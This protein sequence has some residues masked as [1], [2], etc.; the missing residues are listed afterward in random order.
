MPLPGA[1]SSNTSLEH[2]ETPRHHA[3][4]SA[5]FHYRVTVRHSA[6]TLH[7]TRA[8]V[9]GHLEIAPQADSYRRTPATRESSSGRHFCRSW[10]RVNR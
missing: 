2:T 8:W 3:T 6:V 5:L 4:F 7:Y 10:Y 1:S 9:N